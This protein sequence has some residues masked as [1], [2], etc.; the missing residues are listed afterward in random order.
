MVFGIKCIFNL[1]FSTYD[2]VIPIISREA[3]VYVDELRGKRGRIFLLGEKA[4]KSLGQILTY[5]WES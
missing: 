1:I 2:G 5:Q 3:S 4:Y